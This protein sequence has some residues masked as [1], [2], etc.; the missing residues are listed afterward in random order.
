M[1]SRTLSFTVPRD[2]G[3]IRLD[4]FLLCQGVN[5]SRSRTQRLIQSGS[6][7]VDG[8]VRPPGYL[9][10]PGNRIELSLEPAAE[11]RTGPQAEDIPLKI[12]HEDDRLLVV[13]KPAGMVV[14]PA[15]GNYRGTLVNALLGKA[16]KLSPGGGRER[17]GIIHRLDK[18][19]SGLLLVA[20]DQEAHRRLAGQLAARGVRRTYLAAVWGRL[21]GQGTVSAPVGRSAFDRKKMGVTPLRGREAI[22]RYRVLENFGRVASL[23][24]LSLETGRT[25]QIRVHMEHIGHPVIGDPAYVKGVGEIWR[26]LS[27]VEKEAARTAQG[28]MGRQALHAF[29]LRFDHPGDGRKVE[30]E[31][32]PPPDMADLLAFLA[33]NAGPAVSP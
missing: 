17:P 18:D 31:S 24:E 13:D 32:P 14:H 15:P 3:R 27:R 22:T 29:R 6:V 25:H 16:V 12:V 9:V 1:E 8:R 19:T 21:S 30:L 33:K 5:F 26:G 7:T 23:V 20:K 4:R 10:K 11:E 2:Q 28:M